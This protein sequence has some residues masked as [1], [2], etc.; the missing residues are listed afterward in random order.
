MVSFLHFSTLPFLIYKNNTITVRL[1]VIGQPSVLPV[2]IELWCYPNNE[3]TVVQMKKIMGFN[4]YSVFSGETLIDPSYNLQSYAF[5]V[6]LQEGDT[7]W[8][9]S[10]KVSINEPLAHERFTVKLQ[11]S[12]SLWMRD[13]IFYQIFPDRFASSKIPDEEFDKQMDTTP[14]N[15]LYKRFNGDL[16]GIMNK[17]D[18]IQ[19]LGCT[20]IYLNPITESTEVHGYDCNDFFKVD[21]HFGTNEE[22]VELINEVHK[23][24]MKVIISLP[25][26]HVGEDHPLYDVKDLTGKGACH[27]ED[28]PYRSCFTFRDG[29]PVYWKKVPHLVKLDY[30]SP[31]V[32]DMIYKGEDS[33][34]KHYLKRPYQVDGYHIASAHM[35]GSNGSAKD[36]MIYLHDINKVAKSINPECY[37]VC[38]HYYDAKPWLCN[39]SQQ[40]DSALNLFGF[41][42]PMIQYLSGKDYYTREPIKYSAEDFKN[43]IERY[44]TGIAY[45]TLC[46]LFNLIGNHDTRRIA[47]IFNNN[48]QLIR[49]A[50]TMMY[51]WIGV[52]CIYYGD[53]IGLTGEKD[54]NSRIPMDWTNEKEVFKKLI[55]TLAKFRQENEVM[56]KGTLAITFAKDTIVVYERCYQENKSIVII[57]SGN[58]VTTVNL[59]ENLINFKIQESL[60]LEDESKTAE[61]EAKEKRGRYKL[62]GSLIMDNIRIMNVAD[63][64][65]NNSV[66]IGPTSALI[67][68]V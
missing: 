21:P 61:E 20:G 31:Y 11:E 1:A 47:T 44:H 7:K 26:N 45:D 49:I 13:Q 25:I 62:R 67:I 38:E 12:G 28:S 60:A 18:Y 8:V 22:F 54:H 43:F 10:R 16:K 6:Y 34:I 3:P 36:N 35:I 55:V 40:G 2:K 23:R 15:L 65:A 30:A 19:S 14:E 37:M 4:K 33:V 56:T 64:D 5:R 63:L 17:L 29:Q 42:K 59:T 51:T 50:L 39:P 48:P 27:H 32:Q 68:Q 46:C 52:P 66:R 58:N 41:Y 24:N 57:N 9:T 53:E